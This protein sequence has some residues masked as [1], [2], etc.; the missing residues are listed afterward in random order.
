LAFHPNAPILATPG[1]KGTIIRIWDL[2]IATLLGTAPPSLSFHYTNAKVVL[3]GD[4][5]VGKSGLGLVLTGQ[6]F[7]PTESTH[8]RHVWTFDDQEVKLDNLQ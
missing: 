3:V 5:G 6:P 7:V 1:E 4:S 2:D 8:A